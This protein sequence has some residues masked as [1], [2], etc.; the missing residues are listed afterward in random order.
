MCSQPAGPHPVGSFGFYVP[1]ADV[2]MT[3][4]YF[5]LNHGD[6]SILLHPNS[7]FPIIDQSDAHAV[8]QAVTLQWLDACFAP[9]AVCGIAISCF[10]LLCVFVVLVCCSGLNSFWIKQVLP[11]DLS[12]LPST[13]P[14]AMH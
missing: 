11:L 12:Q 3:I 7:G 2:L 10:S 4:Q 1:L 9:S 13:D 8:Q 5:S 14:P 6:L